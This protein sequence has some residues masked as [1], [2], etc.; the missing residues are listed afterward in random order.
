MSEALLRISDVTKRY[1]KQMALQNVSFDVRPGRIVGLL[2]PNGSGKTTLIKIVNGL[3]ADYTG[4]VSVCGYQPGVE[5]KKL[6]SYLPDKMS[7]PTWLRV[8]EAMTV[9]GRFFR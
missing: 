6:V 9:Y 4:E 2:G 8:R 3:L 5:S 7:L 1:G